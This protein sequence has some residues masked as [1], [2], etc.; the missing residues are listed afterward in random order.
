MRPF[1]NCSRGKASSNYPVLFS[2]F[3]PQS[4]IVSVH[5]LKLKS[6][7]QEHHS[8]QKHEWTIICVIEYHKTARKTMARCGLSASHCFSSRLAVRVHLFFAPR[9]MAQRSLSFVNFKLHIA[10]VLI[11]Q[12]LLSELTDTS[13]ASLLPDKQLQRHL[14]VSERVKSDN[15]KGYYILDAINSAIDSRKKISF[16]YVDYDV[17]GK[18]F[19]KHDGKPYIVSPYEMIWDGDFYYVVGYNDGRSKVQNF[20]LDRIAKRPEVL[21]DDCEP[22]PNGF[23]LNLY[24]K[25]IFQMFGADNTTCV[26]LFCHQIVMK[27]LIDVFGIDVET[28]AADTEHFTA[29]I[30]VCV[31]PTFLRWVFGWNGLVKIVSPQKVCEDYRQMLEN[32]LKTQESCG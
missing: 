25:S 5:L 10:H 17:T 24:R 31:S 14:D 27:A 22:M 12:R 32:A 3:A 4:N 26:E 29:W 9:R 16:Q 21:E 6:S 18:Q 7:P 13:K 11:C 19:L 28:K 20:R 23:D 1:S 30:K 2:A 15:E 8:A